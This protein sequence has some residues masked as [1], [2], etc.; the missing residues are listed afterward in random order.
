MNQLTGYSS[1]C[2]LSCLPGVSFNL[3]DVAA[4]EGLFNSPW[5]RVCCDYREVGVVLLEAS[6]EELR[7]QHIEMLSYSHNL[8]LHMQV[9]N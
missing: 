7:A 4:L 6:S 5:T 9:I 3:P 2:D 1:I 8:R